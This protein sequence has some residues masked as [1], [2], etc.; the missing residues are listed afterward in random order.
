MH[1]NMNIFSELFYS[2]TN[3]KKYPQFLQN[4]ILKVLGYVV[5][6]VFLFFINFI[7]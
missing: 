6:V 5:L 7:P 2:I 3:V 1:N 4:K